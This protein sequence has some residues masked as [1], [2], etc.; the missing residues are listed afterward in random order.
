MAAL[1]LRWFTVLG[2]ERA[3]PDRPALDALDCERRVEPGV[4]GEPLS[5]LGVALCRNDEQRRPIVR[6]AERSAEH[7]HALFGQA[8]DE[9][10]MLVPTGLLAPWQRPVPFWAWQF[11]DQEVAHLFSL[12]GRPPRTSSRLSSRPADETRS[13]NRVT[14][15]RSGAPRPRRP[16]AQP[17][18]ARRAPGRVRCRPPRAGT[19]RRCLRSR[20]PRRSSAFVRLPPGR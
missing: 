13:R 11:G 19:D 2:G 14:S 8:V 12:T 4:A 16:V 5:D 10:G 9:R 17:G 7:D 20:M 3:D 15:R 1:D 6:I 18:T